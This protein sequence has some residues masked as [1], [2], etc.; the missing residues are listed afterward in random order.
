MRSA[1]PLRAAPATMGDTATDVGRAGPRRRRARRARPAPDRS[2][3]SGWTGRSRRVGLG[4]GLEHAGRRAAPPRPRRSGRASRRPRAGV[5]RST[6]GSRSRPLVGPVDAWVGSGSSVTGS[7]RS[8]R[9][10]ASA[11]SAV[12]SAA[13]RPRPGAACGTGGWRGRGRR[14]GTRWRRRS[15]E[16]RHGLPRLAREAPPRLRVDGAGERVGDG[17]EVGADV[18]AVQHRRRRRC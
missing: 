10:H 14:G 5:R 13:W 9:P 11:I 1:G 3:R 15:V 12:T 4:D 7:R 6:P 16:G 8:P 2:T 18:Q 17:V